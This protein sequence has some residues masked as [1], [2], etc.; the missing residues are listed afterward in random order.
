MGEN[1]Q[2]LIWRQTGSKYLAWRDEGL[3]AQKK[4]LKQSP[5]AFSGTCH[6]ELQHF[7]D[8]ETLWASSYQSF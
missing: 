1:L 3:A 8:E 4:D 6:V 2:M 7:D 5:Q